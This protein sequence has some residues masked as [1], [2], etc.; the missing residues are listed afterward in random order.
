MIINRFDED[1]K[2]RFI[3]DVFRSMLSSNKFDYNN[4]EIFFCIRNYEISFF[5]YTFLPV[6]GNTLI[7]LVIGVTTAIGCGVSKYFC[8]SLGF[9]VYVIPSCF[10][11]SRPFRCGLY[12]YGSPGWIKGRASGS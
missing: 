11:G 6:G 12:P 3:S 9:V 4:I 7:L 8:N 10:I 2:V 1:F 5:L